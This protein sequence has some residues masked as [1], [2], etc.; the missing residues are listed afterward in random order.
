MGKTKAP[1]GGQTPGAA[2]DSPPTLGAAAVGSLGAGAHGLEAKGL[3]AAI[4]SA[5]APAINAGA[6]ALADQ[7]CIGGSILLE[8]GK[9][10]APSGGQTSGAATDP[11]PTLGTTAAGSPS[12][13]QSATS[14]TLCARID[15]DLTIV[16]IPGSIG[17]NA[18]AS[19]ALKPL[20]ASFFSNWP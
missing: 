16:P 1:S 8:M 9:T 7:S 18:T 10:K 3:V 20:S 14:T 6:G 19:G 17:V 12:I 4:G 15:P 13:G 2:P 11:P 5:L